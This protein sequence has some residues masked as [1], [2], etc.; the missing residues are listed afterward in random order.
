MDLLHSYTPEQNSYTYISEGTVLIY[1]SFNSWV[2]TYNV[3]N[4]GS[5]E[6][7]TAFFYIIF[8]SLFQVHY[9]VE[10]YLL[11]KSL[12]QVNFMIPSALWRAHNIKTKPKTDP[13]GLM[14]LPYV[15]VFLLVCPVRVKPTVNLFLSCFLVITSWYTGR[16]EATPGLN[17]S[18]GAPLTLHHLEPAFSWWKM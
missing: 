4:D 13:F 17:L 6:W 18:L 12:L 15:T 3:W 2:G 9:M 16:L 5:K 8:H 11:H 10:N 1:L 14:L 7:K